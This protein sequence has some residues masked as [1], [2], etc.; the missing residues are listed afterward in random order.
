MIAAA[1][2]VEI[3]VPFAAAFDLLDWSGEDWP[4]PHPALGI[5]QWNWGELEKLNFY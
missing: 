2:R 1:T 5:D 3:Q 4:Q